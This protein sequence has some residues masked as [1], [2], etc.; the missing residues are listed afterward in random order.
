MYISG[1]T[2]VNADIRDV[3]DRD[4]W[5]VMVLMTVLITIMLGF[6]TRSIIAPIYMIGSI[7]LSFAATLGLSY[8]LFEVFLD[9]DGINYRIPLYAFV[10]LVAL[11]VDYSIMLIARVR[12]EM[13][14]MPFDEAV[15]KG[16]ERTGGVISS[17]GLILAATFLVLA[18][19]PI[20][21]LKLFG[22]IMAL[23]ILIDTFIVRP[24]LIPA[25]LVLLGKWSFWPKKM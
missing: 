14:V 9:L 8:Y 19:M 17:A 22:F 2:A 20:Y 11:G 4:T 23:G 12:E 18:T 21:E 6:Q 7:L 15:R 24:L 13:K 10:F 16:V 3:N 1:E 5:I 25:V